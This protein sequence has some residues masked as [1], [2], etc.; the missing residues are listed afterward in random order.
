MGDVSEQLGVLDVR[1]EAA[2]ERAPLEIL[3]QIFSYL[4]RNDR[5]ATSRYSR[6][7]RR[8]NE[9][10]TWKSMHIELGDSSEYTDRTERSKYFF[11]NLPYL[12][13]TLLR[14]K[15]LGKYTAKLSLKVSRYRTYEMMMDMKVLRQFSS[16]QELSLSPPPSDFDLPIKPTSLRL[17]FHY[18]RSTFWK[19]SCY[20]V[21][22]LKLGQYF[23]MPDLRKLQIEHI[24]F[25][26][27]MHEDSFPGPQQ[28]SPI[29]T[30]TFVDCSP[31]TVGVLAKML[32][33]VKCLKFLCLDFNVPRPVMESFDGHGH[34][35]GRNWPG[36]RDYG[37][38]ISPQ[39]QSL[40]EL[41]IAFSDGAS[42]FIG[43]SL[44]HQMGNLG[45]FTNLRRL[46]IPEPLLAR[47]A[48]GTRY[49][50]NFLPKLLEEIQL[51]CPVEFQVLP[52]SPLGQQ[53]P[54]TVRM[55]AL[56]RDKEIFLPRLKLVI[57]WYQQ[58]APSDSA[59]PDGEM[60]GDS[61]GSWGRL[62]RA[63]NAVGVHM[64]R[65][66]GSFFED[67][68]FGQPLNISHSRLRPPNL[69]RQGQFT[70]DPA[71]P[72]LYYDLST[73]SVF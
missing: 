65:M 63:F 66:S 29:E 39:S 73:N 13:T 51:Q 35:W 18:D 3:E 10:F 14:Y 27:T 21:P 47:D 8:I 57:C 53:R 17:D 71:Q 69:V 2:I 37:L 43:R 4:P 64:H 52:L 36:G 45:K 28:P 58:Y 59:S 40:E 38:A 61:E 48:G 1:K 24:S 44:V 33:S 55:H 20:E 6:K 46:A 7:I 31:L 68:P 62:K 19:L 32:L 42:F 12:Y 5:L 41:M 30:L 23:K 9:E 49:S 15:H 67:T 16:L 56:A 26:P 60:V 25:E 34:S 22:R 72:G 70:Y 11:E 54:R 50:S